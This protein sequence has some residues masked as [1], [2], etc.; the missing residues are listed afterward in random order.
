MGGTKSESVEEIPSGWF[1]LEENKC[2]SFDL[3][4]Q[5]KLVLTQTNT[6]HTP[7]WAHLT[8][9]LLHYTHIVKMKSYIFLIV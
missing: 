6:N 1:C 9:L 2:T 8:N 7:Q 3:F 5:E 4:K